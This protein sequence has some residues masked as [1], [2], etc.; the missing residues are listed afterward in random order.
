MSGSRSTALQQKLH[1]VEEVPTCSDRTIRCAGISFASK[2]VIHLEGQ[3][4]SKRRY[5]PTR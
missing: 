1:T 5:N 2:D 3:R 4:A